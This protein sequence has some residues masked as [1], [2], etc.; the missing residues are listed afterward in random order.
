MCTLYSGKFLKVQNF[1]LNAFRRIFGSSYVATVFLN[2]KDLL[3]T[4][5]I[6]KFPAIYIIAH[7]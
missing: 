2:F 1:G 3:I 6:L 4:S 7:G 5:K